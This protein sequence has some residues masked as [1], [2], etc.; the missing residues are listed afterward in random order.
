MR[1]RINKEWFSI[2]AISLLFLDSQ[3]HYF[4]NTIAR[5]T[6]IGLVN[7]LY[8]L[9]RYGVMI[10]FVFFIGNKI[11][12]SYLIYTVMISLLLGLSAL[13]S[14]EARPYVSNDLSTILYS[15]L[16]TVYV[17]AHANCMDKLD[18]IVECSIKVAGLFIAVCFPINELII[19]YNTPSTKYM[20][21]SYMV[22]TGAVGF[23]Y[24]GITKLKVMDIIIGVILVIELC[25][26]GARGPL[27]CVVAVIFISAIRL[28][29]SKNYKA[30]ATLMS[31][32]ILG[33]VLVANLD[34]LILMLSQFGTEAGLDLRLI[35]MIQSDNFFESKSTDLRDQFQSYMWEFIQ[36]N[37]LGSGVYSDRVLGGKLG[38]GVAYAHNIL[39]EFLMNYGIILG[40][41]GIILLFTNIIQTLLNPNTK[42]KATI[43]VL[44]SLIIVKLFVSSSYWFEPLF[45][46]MIYIFYKCKK[47]KYLHKLEGERLRL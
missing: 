13:F 21:M 34:N 12:K 32:G 44:I 30:T 40:G 28:A 36:E 41:A 42:Y 24:Y 1:F 27:L 20:S 7:I 25:I 14:R 46:F 47:E 45:F 19:G 43:D 3:F 17:C 33:I 11:K 29:Q 31:L 37:P 10:G 16:W 8:Y 5:I 18:K 15:S 9:I 22:V 4:I 2:L 26:A 39:Y 38:I 35:N 6:N 23:L